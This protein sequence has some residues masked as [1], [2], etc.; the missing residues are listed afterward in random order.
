M[1]LH[2]AVAAQTS[3]VTLFATS[4][5]KAVLAQSVPVLL[6]N[7]PIVGLSIGIVAGVSSR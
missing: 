7:I 1:G 6:S 3:G 4:M 2:T 5:R